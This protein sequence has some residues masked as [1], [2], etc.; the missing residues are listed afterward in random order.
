MIWRFRSLFLCLSDQR[1]EIGQHGHAHEKKSARTQPVDPYDNLLF[2]F[3]SDIS[4]ILYSTT[5]TFEEILLASR[6]RIFFVGQ[7]CSSYSLHKTAVA[8]TLSWAFLAKWWGTAGHASFPRCALSTYL[9][10]WSHVDVDLCSLL[11]P[12]FLQ[13]MIG[14]EQNYIS[15]QKTWTVPLAIFVCSCRSRFITQG[16]SNSALFSDCTSSPSTLCLPLLTSIQ[17]SSRRIRVSI[18]VWLRVVGSFPL[19]QLTLMPYWQTTDG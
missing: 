6:R 8:I 16:L 1:V 4:S 7:T 15:Y 13:K 10:R 3:F 17:Q 2:Q 18:G 19:F 11:Q 9:L 12:S 5:S 14:V